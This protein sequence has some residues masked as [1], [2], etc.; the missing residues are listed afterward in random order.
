[1]VF[2]QSYSRSATSF[3][4][5][6]FPSF[7]LRLHKLG[8]APVGHHVPFPLSHEA[9]FFVFFSP[10]PFF[11]VLLLFVTETASGSGQVPKAA[12]VFWNQTLAGAGTNP[13]GS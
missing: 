10:F 3:G 13:F 12:A 7:F 9:S 11:F 6:S 2:R 8:Q 4:P 1:M 5:A